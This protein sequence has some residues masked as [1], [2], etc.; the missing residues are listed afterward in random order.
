MFEIEIGD[1]NET[2]D[3]LYLA[4]TC[5][6]EGEAIYGFEGSPEIPF[7]KENHPDIGS[8]HYAESVIGVPLADYYDVE[9]GGCQVVAVP[10][11]E[12]IN[13][14]EFA[15]MYG[16]SWGFDHYKDIKFI[17]ELLTGMGV[18]KDDKDTTTVQQLRFISRVLKL[19]MLQ[20]LKTSR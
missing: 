3:G 5:A 15:D 16:K 2:T 6:K 17:P 12:F 10:V 9:K 8:Q 19:L 13:N 4:L 1:K 14:A 11:S 18:V 7:T 20:H